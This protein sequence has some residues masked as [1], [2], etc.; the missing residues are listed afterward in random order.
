[1]EAKTTKKSVLQPSKKYQAKNGFQLRIFSTGSLLD[2]RVQASITKYNG[3]FTSSTTSKTHLKKKHE[4]L[5]GASSTHSKLMCDPRNLPL[6]KYIKTYFSFKYDT[7]LYM[8]NTT[9]QQHIGRGSK[10]LWMLEI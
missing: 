4:L 8:L 5:F 2:I 7:H 9:D 1:M 3:N 10:Q 6:P